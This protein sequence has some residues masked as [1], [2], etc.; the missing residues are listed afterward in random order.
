MLRQIADSR[1]LIAESP[2]TGEYAGMDPVRTGKI[3]HVPAN[4]L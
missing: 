3:V 1:R 4:Y 2:L